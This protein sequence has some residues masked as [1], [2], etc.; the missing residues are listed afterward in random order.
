MLLYALWLASSCASWAAA[1]ADPVF[2]LGAIL[3]PP[4]EAK[5]LAKT[6][7]GNIVTEQVLYRSEMDGP[8]RVDVTW[9]FSGPR[10]PAAAQ[11]IVSYGDDGNWSSRCWKRVMAT[12]KEGACT[13]A[14]PRS[15]MVYY[16][17]GNLIDSDGFISSTPLVRID[18]A[19]QGLHDAQ[20]AM[21]Y[22]GAAMWGRFEDEQAVFLQRC[23]CPVPSGAAGPEPARIP[24]SS[25]APPTCDC[26]CCLRPVSRT[27]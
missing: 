11:L 2:D 9:T 20:A 17:G 8:K 16:A 12:I 22:D 6:E 26:R 15:P 27:G 24:P 5:V 3:A 7:N 13:A 25:A 18:P 10:K 23:A 21:D 19:R 1:P 4:L 14:L